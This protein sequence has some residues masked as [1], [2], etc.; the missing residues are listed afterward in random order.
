MMFRLSTTCFY[1][2][3]EVWDRKTETKNVFMTQESQFVICNPTFCLQNFFLNWICGI[4]SFCHVPAPLPCPM[5][6]T[7]TILTVSFLPQYCYWK[8]MAKAATLIQNKYRLYCEHK[9]HKKSQQA[10]TCI[11]NYYRNYKEHQQRQTGSKE[12]TPTTGIKWVADDPS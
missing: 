4:N 1:I 8:Q 9:R 2:S 7:F 3:F 12:S 10:A 5:F 11:Q 6:I